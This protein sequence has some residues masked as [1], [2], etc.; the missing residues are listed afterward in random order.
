MGR[1]QIR[2]AYLGETALTTLQE[3]STRENDIDAE[4]DNM[5]STGAGGDNERLASPRGIYHSANNR[6]QIVHDHLMRSIDMMLRKKRMKAE[7]IAHFGL[8]EE[9]ADQQVEQSIASAREDVNQAL[10]EFGE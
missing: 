8:S 2:R 10:G 3:S 9:Q 5:Q 6:L 7:L 4:T 1:L